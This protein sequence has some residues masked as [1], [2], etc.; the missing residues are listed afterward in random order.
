MGMADFWV[1]VHVAAQNVGRSVASKVSIHT[2]PIFYPGGYKFTEDI[3]ALRARA[4]P[5]KMLHKVIAPN[6]TEPLQITSSSWVK[7]VDDIPLEDEKLIKGT[8]VVLV[9]ISYQAMGSVTGRTMR[10]FIDYKRVIDRSTGST[11][12]SGEFAPVDHLLNEVE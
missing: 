1:G 11:H 9:A 3:N 2:T 12:S 5:S 6:D 7:D 8:L 4:R 10:A